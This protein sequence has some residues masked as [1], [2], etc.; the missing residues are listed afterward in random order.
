MAVQPSLAQT[1]LESAVIKSRCL[2]LDLDAPLLVP[3][4]FSDNNP[5]YKDFGTET[6]TAA[7]LVGKGGH[8]RTVAEFPR[9]QWPSRHPF[10]PE[11][12]G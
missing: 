9:T 8:V 5:F 12:L 11:L 3:H 1:G 4:A 6:V 10:W 7:Y 2:W